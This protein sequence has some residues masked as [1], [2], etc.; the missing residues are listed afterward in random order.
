MLLSHS[1]FLHVEEPIEGRVPLTKLLVR[2]S[3][4]KPFPPLSNRR[5]P[6]ATQHIPNMKGIKAIFLMLFFLTPSMA[7]S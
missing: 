1:K 5:G 6:L 3:N 7:A 4:I 2:F